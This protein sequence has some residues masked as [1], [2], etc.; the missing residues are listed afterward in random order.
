ML[1]TRSGCVQSVTGETP[2]PVNVPAGCRFATRCHRK[3][4]AICDTVA[5]PIRQMSKTHQIACHIEEERLR[6]ERPIYVLATG[7]NE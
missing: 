7:G 2:S 5:P 1:S 3:V 6:A 4:G